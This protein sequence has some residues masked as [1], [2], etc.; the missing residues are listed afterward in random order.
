M[1]AVLRQLLRVLAITLLFALSL[2]PS[3]AAGQG[4]PGQAMEAAETTEAALPP[5]LTSMN[6]TGD[7]IIGKLLEHNRLQNGQLQQY[8]AVRTYE[9]RNASGKLSAQ[10]IVRVDYRAPDKKTFTKTS[11]KGSW[12]VRHLVFDRLMESETETS[13]GREHHDSAITSANYTFTLAGEEDLGPYHCFVVEATPKR[14]DKYLFEG[15]IW[16][17]V[18]D[19]A[20]V[21][22]A[23]HPAKKPSF[24]IKRADFVRQYQ[25]IDGFWL[26]YKDE[27][28]VDVKIHGRKIFTIEHQ[29]YSINDSA[30]AEGRTQN[31]IGD[32]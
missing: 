1:A 26:P 4:S 23:G 15:K 8:S 10:A 13:S 29:S 22:I 28:F 2:I 16:I 11:E 14:K 24:W 7:D 3:S 32:N 21:R 18:Q 6:L 25:R 31:S 12:I 17:D 30:P 5:P 9:V 19:F 27:T 20:V